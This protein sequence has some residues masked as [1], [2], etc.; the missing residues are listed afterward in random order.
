M[1]T[2]GPGT[3]NYQGS[4]DKFESIYT[5]PSDH[6]MLMQSIGAS[7]ASLRGQ[8]IEDPPEDRTLKRN[9]VVNS[10]LENL[11]ERDTLNRTEIIM[12]SKRDKINTSYCQSNN[13]SYKSA[14]KK[15]LAALANNNPGPGA[16]LTIYETIKRKNPRAVIGTSQRKDLTSKH[17]INTP[18]PSNYLPNIDA[19][20]KSSSHWTMSLGKRYESIER[21]ASNSPGPA[22]YQ[23]KIEK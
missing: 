12:N 19:V 13:G 9:T 3:Y 8:S 23:P 1:K 6:S 17:I 18:G 2:P 22:D 5:K 14:A 20:K 10:S 21:E 15:T 16:Y 4:F 11:K 7:K